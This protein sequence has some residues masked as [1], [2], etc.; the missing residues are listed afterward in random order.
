MT[1]AEIAAC[2]E[3]IPTDDPGE[4]TPPVDEPTDPTTP[5]DPIAT[6]DPTPTA[7]AKPLEKTGASVAFLGDVGV[8]ALLAGA[9]AL[10]ARKRVYFERTERSSATTVGSASSSIVRQR[11]YSLV[12]PMS[13][14]V[15]AKD[16]IAWSTG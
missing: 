15:R 14:A 2:T 7:P 11:S 9:A 6:G 4:T 8:L 1:D 3:G 5:S 10:V 13:C 12:S 16:A